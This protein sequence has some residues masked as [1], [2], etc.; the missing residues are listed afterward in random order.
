MTAGRLIILLAWF[1]VALP[2]ALTDS[3]NAPS[4]SIF[5]FGD[6]I[7][8]AGNNHFNKNCTAQADFP[9]YGSS[10]FHRPTGRF[11]NGRTV[12]DFIS[13]YMGVP[14]QKSFLE[15][16]LELMNGTSKRFPSNG[17]NFASAG[18]GVLQDTNKDWGV[19]PIQTQLQQFQTLV[20]QNQV[21]K[22]L[23]QESLFFFESGSNDIYDY[24]LPF[25]T[26][27]LSP[28]A[29]VDA[30][31]VQATKAID[32]ICQLGGR[33]IAV[34]S[35][36][37]VGCVPARAL[38]PGAP[39]DKCFGKMNYMV[40]KYNK[41]LEDM[42]K[43]LTTRYKGVTAVFGAVYG[44]TQRLRTFPARYGLVDVTNA[45]CGDGALG[46]MIQCGRE[47]Y[48]ECKNPNE[49]LFWDY[50]HPTEHTYGLIAGALWAGNNADVRPLNLSAL[51]SRAPTH[52]QRRHPITKKGRKE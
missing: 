39:I 5:I 32:Q 37:P 30:M 21:E 19:I 52:T 41:G 17:V 48:K 23:I 29:Y 22:S 44:I 34:F 31:L 4:P 13:Q 14:L 35:L 25:D 10:F 51:A 46:G 3:D 26:P 6:S 36:G 20:D 43:N 18:S 45:C 33:R 40:K 49:Y 28:D 47:G 9:P 7:F 16:Q 12:P 8:D 50:F 38:L 27:A 2:R 1:L 42:V 11:T 24:F 15:V